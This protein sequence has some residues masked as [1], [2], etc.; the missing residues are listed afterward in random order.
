MNEAVKVLD[1]ELAGATE[2]L[3]GQERWIAASRPSRG[4]SKRTTRSF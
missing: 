1:A 3:A 2:E 4:W